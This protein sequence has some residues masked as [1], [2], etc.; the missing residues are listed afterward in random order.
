MPSRRTSKSA[1]FMT[2]EF[3]FDQL[4]GHR[5]A[6][7]GNESIFMA[8][9][10]LMNRPCYQFLAGP[11]FAQNANTCF[12]CGHALDLREQLLQR[13]ARS[14]QLVFPQTMPQFTVFVFEARKPQGI[15]HRDQ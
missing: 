8:L 6:I 3:R 7:Q 9:R 13:R 4:R 15:L 14:N 1:L 12:A 5:G 2:K 10:L 11:G